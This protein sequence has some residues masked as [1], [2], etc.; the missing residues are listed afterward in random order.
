LDDRTKKPLDENL[1]ALSRSVLH[2]AQADAEQILAD[3]RAKA[4]T[5]LRRA[6]EKAESEHETI[7]EQARQEAND[8]RSEAIAGAELQAQTKL[9]ERREKLLD[10]VF[11]TAQ[12]QLPAIRQWTDYDEIVQQLVREAVTHVGAD[13]VVIHTDAQTQKLMS[14]DRL[15]ELSDELGVKLQLGTTLERG[16]GVTAETMDGHRQY[17]NTL[18]VRLERLQAALRSPVYR[19]LM[20]KAA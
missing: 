4:D 13:T 19:L 5:V 2:E 14:D 8:L 6:H 3:A 1:S 17:D 11:E 16:I 18:Q 10:H 15:D 12:Q 7:L 9:L 20:G